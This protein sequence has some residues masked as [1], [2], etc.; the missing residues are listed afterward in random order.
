MMA[1]LLVL[2]SP[3]LITKVLFFYTTSMGQTK[4]ILSWCNQPNYTPLYGKAKKALILEFHRPR[5]YLS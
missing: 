3:A 4:F 2:I 1:E 5:I